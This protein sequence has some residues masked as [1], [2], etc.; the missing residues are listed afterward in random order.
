MIFWLVISIVSGSSL[1]AGNF[2]TLQAC[3]AAAKSVWLQ[4]SNGAATSYQAACIE[5]DTGKQ[6]DPAPPN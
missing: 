6:G 1:H 4:A 2:P 3:Q 5:A